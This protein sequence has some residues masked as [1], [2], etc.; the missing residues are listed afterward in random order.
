[1]IRIEALRQRYRSSG[2][3]VL[4]GLNLEVPEG[5]LFGLLGPNG[6]GKTTLINV[7][8]GLTGFQ[9]GSIKVGG[10]KIPEQLSGLRG[11]V[12][13]APQSL[14]FYPTLTGRENLE[15]F[16]R[17]G[18][19]DGIDA[20]IE[21]TG[22]ERHLSRP[23]ARLSGGLKRRLNLAIALVSVPALLILDEPTVGV[24][25]QSRGFILAALREINAAGTTIL[26]TT[27]YLDEVE[28][29]CKR[30]AVIDHGRVLACGDLSELVGRPGDLESLFLR[31]TGAALRDER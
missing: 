15:F 9:E 10:R 13:L 30:A 2:P 20:A 21:R 7:L 17:I 27:H 31:L 3:W 1:M 6:A 26:Y 5:C 18:G 11:K 4:D 12:G 25:I 23:A 29:L 8:L 19:A 16:A 14:A 28:R 24:D 22:L